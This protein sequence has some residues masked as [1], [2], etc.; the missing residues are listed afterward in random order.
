MKEMDKLEDIEL[1]YKDIMYLE[2]FISLKH[3]RQSNNIRASQFAPFAALTGF[4]DQILDAGKILED[5]VFLGEDRI[6]EINEKLMIISKKIYNFEVVITYFISN[7]LKKGGIFKE[8]IGR[9]RRIDLDNNLLVFYD[10]ER[11]K[12]E[13]IVNIEIN[14]IHEY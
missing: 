1:K 3:P 2:H 13:D 8:K 4:N 6:D 7:N 12:I 14:D 11:I 9:V 5:K 10:S